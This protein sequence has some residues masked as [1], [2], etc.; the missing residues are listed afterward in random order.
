[1][2]KLV[3]IAG[4]GWLIWSTSLVWPEMNLALS[5]P[6]MPGLAAWLAVAS[7]FYLASRQP[8][9]CPIPPRREQPNRPSRPVPLLRN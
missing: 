8:G 6:V 2:A 1:V 5:S 9:R 4:L 3:R 7:L